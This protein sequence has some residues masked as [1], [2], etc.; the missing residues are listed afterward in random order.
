M[1][2]QRVPDGRPVGIR[3]ARHASCGVRQHPRDAPAGA[4]LASVPVRRRPR[5]LSSTTA[6]PRPPRST[7]HGDFPGHLRRGAELAAGRGHVA[8]SSRQLAL[9][10]IQVSPTTYCSQKRGLV[11]GNHAHGPWTWRRRATRD[12]HDPVQ[13]ALALRD[14]RPRVQRDPPDRVRGLHA[15]LLRDGRC[16]L[17]RRRLRHRLRLPAGLRG[18]VLV[19]ASPT[20]GYGAGFGWGAFTGFAF[21][22]IAAGAWGGAWGC[23]EYDDIDINRNV[24][25]NRNDAYRRW[26]QGQVRS[27]LESRGHR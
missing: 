4:V 13:L 11:R 21:G 12:L 14:L 1:V 16:P 6:S 10:V 15:G 5:R 18:R 24:N 22:A 26:N 2:P 23:C 20:Y 17:Q 7:W 3:G 9:P 25:I 27:N 19:S 8:A